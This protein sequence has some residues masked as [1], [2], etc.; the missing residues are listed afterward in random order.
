M[1]IHK[2]LR[3]YK[4][5]IISGLIVAVVVA[6][7]FLG[8]VPAVKK[9]MDFQENIAVLR[10]QIDVLRAK[11]NVLDAIDEV[12][13]KKYFADLV[14][15]VPSEKSLTSA[16]TTID[17]LGVQTGVTLTGFTLTNP[18]SLASGSARLGTNFLPFTLTAGL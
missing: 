1:Q 8:I 18:G 9:I 5:L 17:G 12:T 2:F 4:G 14:L 13:Y 6:G 11:A 7:I 15:A 3:V 16:F 10:K